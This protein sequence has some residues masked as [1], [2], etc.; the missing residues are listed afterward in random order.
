MPIVADRL[1]ETNH[2]FKELN[3]GG[4]DFLAYPGEPL[5]H[6][7]AQR[8]DFLRQPHLGLRLRCCKHLR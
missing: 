4:R 5:T 8:T 3:P 1:A 7:D 2:P 6:L